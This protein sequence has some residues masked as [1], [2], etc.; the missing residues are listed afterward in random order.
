METAENELLKRE[1]ETLK[2]ENAELRETN[3]KLK[4]S[5]GKASRRKPNKPQPVP[6]AYGGIDTELQQKLNR[7][8]RQ[9]S[10]VQERLTILE[11]VNAATQRREIRQ[12]GA[13]KNIP[14]DCSFYEELRFDPTDE[15]VYT[16]RQ[17]MKHTGCILWTRTNLHFD[18]KH[19]L[20][21]FLSLSCCI[22]FVDFGWRL[23]LIRSQEAFYNSTSEMM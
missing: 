20:H 1:I 16:R 17:L 10:D 2:R 5:L 23:L 21:I 11:Q 7:T 3:N 19:C 4:L 14:S 22:H 9:L 8:T 13:L 6:T 18:I 15:Y 12:E